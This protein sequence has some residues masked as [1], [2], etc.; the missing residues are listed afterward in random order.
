M[1]PIPFEKNLRER[2]LA[3]GIQTVTLHFSGGND[4]GFLE[5]EL[6]SKSETPLKSQTPGDPL[7]AL[8]S[9]IEDW[10]WDYYPY[11]GTGIGVPYGDVLQYDLQKDSIE[12]HSWYETPPPN[13]PNLS[14]LP[15]LPNLNP[16]GTPRRRKT[17]KKKLQEALAER[18]EARAEAKKWEGL[19]DE[20]ADALLHEVHRDSFEDLETLGECAQRVLNERNQ[21]RELLAMQTRL[22]TDLELRLLKV[23]KDI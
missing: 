18:D 1:T 4:E 8:K 12:C 21:A 20:V 9:E 3:L 14:N 10:A 11:N 7:E 15:N 6:L 22:V 5:V 17:T 2:A 19:Y 16:Q 23:S 13:L